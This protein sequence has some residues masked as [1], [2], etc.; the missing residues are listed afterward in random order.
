MNIGI[1]VEV[2]SAKLGG[3]LSEKSVNFAGET[4]DTSPSLSNPNHTN[5]SK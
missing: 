5:L 4:Q 3:V 2:Q 1:L